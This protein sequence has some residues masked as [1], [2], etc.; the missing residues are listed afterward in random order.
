MDLVLV[1]NERRHIYDAKSGDS[2]LHA[3]ISYLAPVQIV[4]FSCMKP[5]DSNIIK[6][7]K[8]GAA[9]FRFLRNMGF[10]YRCA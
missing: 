8:K 1:R 4:L 6:Q 2:G 5:S 10:R 9:C 3:K 7:E